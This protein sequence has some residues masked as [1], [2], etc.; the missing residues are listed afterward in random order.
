MGEG[1]VR[2]GGDVRGIPLERVLRSELPEV[3][4]DDCGVGGDGEG[5]LVSACSP[6]LLSVHDIEVSG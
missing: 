4:L 6:V 5:S 3:F 1:R 2:E